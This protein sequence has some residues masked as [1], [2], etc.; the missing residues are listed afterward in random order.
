GVFPS[1]CDSTIADLLSTVQ[2]AGEKKSGRVFGPVGG[3]VESGDTHTE[4]EPRYR[5]APGLEGCGC[6][7]R[8]SGWS[9]A[10]PGRSPCTHCRGSTGNCHRPGAPQIRRTGGRLGDYSV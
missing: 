5:V 10:V 1:L 4:R 7:V 2:L 6:G 8:R 3:D 9:P